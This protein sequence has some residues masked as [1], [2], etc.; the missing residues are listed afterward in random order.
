MNTPITYTYEM[1]LKTFKKML[2]ESNISIVEMKPKFPNQKAFNVFEN[3]NHIYHILFTGRVDEWKVIIFTK[4]TPLIA[5]IIMRG[6]KVELHCVTNLE[7]TNRYKIKHGDLR[8]TLGVVWALN[9][10]GGI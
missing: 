9:Y 6:C 4:N 10:W 2:E 1:P 5:D 8:E 7:G 3:E